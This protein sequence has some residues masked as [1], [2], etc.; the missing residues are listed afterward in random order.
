MKTREFDAKMRAFELSNDEKVRP[1]MWV[2]AR[3]DGRNFST[4][5]RKTLKLKPFDEKL[6][7]AMYFTVREIMQESGW[8]CIFGYTHSDEMSILLDKD[9]V[10]TTFDG[11]IRKI[12]SLLA[13]EASVRFSNHMNVFAT[14][15]CRV[16]QLPTIDHVTDYYLWRRGDSE[17]NCLNAWAYYFLLEEGLTGTAAQKKLHKQKPEYKHDL[18]FKHGLNYNSLP[19]WQKR[20]IGLLW[21]DYL[22]DA[23]NQK[24]GEKV[25]VQRQYVQEW[26]NLP[27]DNNEYKVFIE[28]IIHWSKK[29]KA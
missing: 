25:Q 22:K 1:D 19:D 29:Q 26:F 15:D 13:A 16:I 28:N 11:K 8:R 3:I 4:L 17:T 7:D 10:G 12:N 5:T 23:V 14:F 2:I 9:T 21:K 24:T 20:G 18:L 6:R 27:L